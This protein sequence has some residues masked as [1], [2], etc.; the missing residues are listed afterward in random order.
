MGSTKRRGDATPLRQ[1]TWLSPIATMLHVFA[2]AAST[3]TASKA[4]TKTNADSDAFHNGTW[5]RTALDNLLG[6]RFALRRR[7][8]DPL[9]RRRRIDPPGWRRRIDLF[10]ERQRRRNGARTRRPQCDIGRH[11]R[12]S[13]RGVGAERTVADALLH[14]ARYGRQI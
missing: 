2:T 5:R 13:K 9:G 6:R 3:H 14:L 7:C 1:H 11:D 4:K 12:R 8:S 10:L